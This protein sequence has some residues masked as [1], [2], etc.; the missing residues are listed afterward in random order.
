MKSKVFRQISVILSLL[1]IFGSFAPI[2]TY[3]DTSDSA[4]EYPYLDPSLSADERARDLLSR[5]SVE[6]KIA[7]CIQGERK[8]ITASNIPQYQLGSILSGGGS[9]PGKTRLPIGVQ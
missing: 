2:L 5:M 8:I 4:Y 1:M 3:A 7:Q 6:E 9:T